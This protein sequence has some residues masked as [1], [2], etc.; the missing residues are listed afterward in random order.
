MQGKGKQE[1]RQL[2]IRYNDSPIM[3][4]KLIF[5]LADGQFTVHEK[6]F[7][8]NEESYRSRFHTILSNTK[9]M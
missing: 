9:N 8:S 4:E 2:V 7:K 6:S 1:I 5:K 3:F